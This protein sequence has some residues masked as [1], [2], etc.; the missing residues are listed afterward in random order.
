M[1]TV[2]DL[3]TDA[4]LEI[5]VFHV[6]E[7]PGA[8][9]LARGLRRFKSMLGDWEVNG[10]IVPGAQGGGKFPATAATLESPA[11]PETWQEALILN[12]AVV[13]GPGYGKKANS[14]SESTITRATIS[15]SALRARNKSSILT[16]YPEESWGWVIEGAFRE[17]RVILDG[18]R[19]SAQQRDR[20]LGRLNALLDAWSID[21]GIQMPTPAHLPAYVAADGA[22]KRIFTIGPEHA[23]ILAEPPARL[24]TVEYQWAS[25][26]R[27][28][29]ITQVSYEDWVRWSDPVGT[30]P[31]RYYYEATWPTA[32]L[33][34]DQVPLA[35]DTLTLSG[36]PRGCRP[37]LACLT[38]LIGEY[39]PPG[40]A[41]GF[42]L[43]L[44]VELAPAYSKAQLSQ[45]TV[46]N[47]QTAKTQLRQRNRKPALARFDPILTVGSGRYRRGWTLQP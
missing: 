8:D 41:R 9:D 47:A 19:I 31:Q 39:Y 40:Y 33:Y 35:G 29:P 27:G 43:N 25:A 46:M 10:L 38:D 34:L 22:T 44:A 42:L 23:D 6:N 18:E 28:F 24:S 37:S 1:A 21:S 45:V 7:T 11:P 26:D 2:Q 30:Q 3:I 14:F 16:A 32:Q 17:I 4:L 5:G 15:R 12:L 36:W 20:G 13:I